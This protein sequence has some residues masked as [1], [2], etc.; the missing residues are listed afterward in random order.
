VVDCGDGSPLVA[1]VDADTLASLQSAVGA[2]LV[3]PAGVTCSLSV[4]ALDPTVS[5]AA[6]PSS[7][8]FV[9]GGGGSTAALV[10]APCRDVV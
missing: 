3:D 6:N 7:R 8:A 9:V 1:T 4:G 5:I 10:P 2:M